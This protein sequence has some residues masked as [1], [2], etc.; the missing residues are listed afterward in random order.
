MKFIPDVKFRINNETIGTYPWFKWRFEG[1]LLLFLRGV[2]L[3][4]RNMLYWPT[5]E[6]CFEIVRSAGQFCL[7]YFS[8]SYAWRLTFQSRWP[9]VDLKIFR[10]GIKRNDSEVPD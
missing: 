3:D 2:D 5:Y 10:K 7:T 8:K 1:K 4:T 9:L 6:Q